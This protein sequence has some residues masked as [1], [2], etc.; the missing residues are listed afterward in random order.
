MEAQQLGIRGEIGPS[1]GGQRRNSSYI[2]VLA[3][4]IEQFV[5]IG[6][7]HEVAK[8]H[9]SEVLHVL[10][11]PDLVNILHDKIVCTFP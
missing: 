3:I 9:D 4:S 10:Y 6:F 1:T 5:F 2:Y 7:D 11:I 8:K